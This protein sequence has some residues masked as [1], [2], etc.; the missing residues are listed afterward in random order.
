MEINPRPPQYRT[1]DKTS[2]A[3]VSA[4]GRWSII[5]TGALDD[6]QRALLGVTEPTQRLEGER[7]VAGIEKLKDEIKHDEPLT[8]IAGYNKQLEELGTPTW[9]DM[10]WLYAECYIYRFEQSP[11]ACF[12]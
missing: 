1:S 4:R 7:I 3:Y 9:L 2:F 12:L 10:P 6:V 11:S 5:L 8:D